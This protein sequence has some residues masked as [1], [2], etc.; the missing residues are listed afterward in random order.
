M[1]DGVLIGAGDTRRLAWYMLITL[2]AFAPIAG[3][4]LWLPDSFGQSWGMVTLWLGYG[5]VTMAVRAGTQF[6]RTRGTAWMHL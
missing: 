1:L 3:V 5:G 4:V 2:A 6:A